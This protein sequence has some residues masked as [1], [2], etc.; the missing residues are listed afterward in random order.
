MDE[1]LY[2]SNHDA[3]TNFKPKNKII[4]KKNEDRKAYKDFKKKVKIMNK[5]DVTSS[6][7]IFNGYITNSRG[8]MI[9]RIV[10]AEYDGTI[11]KG[12]DV[13][14]CDFNKTN[15]AIDN[16]AQIPSTL[17][18]IIHL[19]YYEMKPNKE[20]IL[21]TLLPDYIK[22]KRIEKIRKEHI[23][24]PEIKDMAANI[25]YQISLRQNESRE[26]LINSVVEVI[27]DFSNINNT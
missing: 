8:I 19:K 24:L 3:M 23:S 14:H 27:K 17:H 15:N 16:L 9:H 2:R 25:G 1:F 6:P 4:V 11:K 13:H 22:N 21:K 12:W 5:L 26:Q 20:Y 10:S 7:R 18:E